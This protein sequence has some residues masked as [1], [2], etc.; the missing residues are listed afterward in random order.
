MSAQPAI[1]KPEFNEPCNGCGYCCTIEP[2]QLAK[3]HLKCQS[4]PC[5]ALEVSGERYLCGFVRNPL[6]YIFQAAHPEQIVAVLDAAPENSASAQ[7]AFEIAQALGVGL[8][9]DADDDEESALW[10]PAVNPDPI[11]PPG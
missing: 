10:P 1:K 11:L 9:C 4:G 3:D 2:C 5:V 7:L 8:G 6:G